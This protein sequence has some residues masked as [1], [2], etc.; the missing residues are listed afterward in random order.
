MYKIRN[1]AITCIFLNCSIR[2]SE[3]TGINLSDIK[4]DK[5]EKTIRIHGKGNKER[6]LYLN[7]AVCEA[8]K[9]YIEV[10][11]KLGKKY[12][13]YYEA[14]KSFLRQFNNEVI[15]FRL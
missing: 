9:A 3:L 15:K 5:S 11:P 1:Y 2:L 14:L 4:I 6:L 12:K 7:A 10:R 8:I 13:D